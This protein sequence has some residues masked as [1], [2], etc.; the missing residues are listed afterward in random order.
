MRS[1]TFHLTFAAVVLAAPIAISTAHAQTSSM[2]AAS[3]QGAM[4]AHSAVTPADRKFFKKAAI[5]GMTEVA[6]GK[7]AA[8]QGSS[9]DV[10]AFGQRMV[11]DHTKA[12]DQLKTLASQKNFALPAVPDAKHQAMLDSLQAK[13]G[14]AFDTAF[15]A[16]MKKG[17]ADAIKVFTAGSQSKDS[18]I[19]QFASATLPTLKDH[20]AHI[21]KSGMAMSSI[22][23]GDA[24]PML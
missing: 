18:D 23:S 20:Q 1:P 9:A 8:V 22:K 24:P 13:Q 19:A 15:I 16:D 17:H 5:G 21:P 4:A 7:L 14:E 11:D 10:K 3:E 2:P 6:A 12:D